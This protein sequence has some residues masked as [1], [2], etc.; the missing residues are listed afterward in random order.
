MK[1]HDFVNLLEDR[2]ARQQFLSKKDLLILGIFHNKKDLNT[3]ES[4]GYAPPKFYV[5]G[6]LL[7]RKQDIINYYASTMVFYQENFRNHETILWNFQHG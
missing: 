7:Y 1:I 5:E 3:A 2:Y 6:K 4:W